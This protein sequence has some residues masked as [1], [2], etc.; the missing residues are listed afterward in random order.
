MK[1][2]KVYSQALKEALEITTWANGDKTARSESGVFYNAN[3]MRLLKG[4]KVPPCVHILKGISG[5]TIIGLNP[6]QSGM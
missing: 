6:T 5:G 2:T 4:H 3:E 1:K